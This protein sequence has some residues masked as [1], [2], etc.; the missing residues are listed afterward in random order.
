MMMNFRVV[1]RSMSTASAPPP[2]PPASTPASAV[3]RPSVYVNGP[4][5][6]KIDVRDSELA[7]DATGLDKAVHYGKKAGWTAVGVGLLAVGASALAFVVLGDVEFLRPRHSAQ[8]VARQAL[9]LMN[10]HAAFV[11]LLGRVSEEPGEVA[12]QL[13]ADNY[14]KSDERVQFK[15]KM[16]VPS[17]PLV[18]TVHVDARRR[19]SS[20][21]EIWSLIVDAPA[22]NK[23]IVVVKKGHLTK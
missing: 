5:G 8:V 2:R 11:R 9:R 19:G 13:K 14:R 12:A 1:S 16:D 4:F 20:D 17:V 7:A 22:L 18:A 3:R 23:R 21:F 6:N 10:Q 15:F